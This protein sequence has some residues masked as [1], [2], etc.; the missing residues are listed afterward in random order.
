MTKPDDLAALGA[1]VD[2]LAREN[3]ELRQLLASRIAVPQVNPL[4]GEV[5]PRL[6]L[7]RGEL[8]RRR[9]KGRAIAFVLMGLGIGVGIAAARLV[10]VELF[11]GERAAPPAAAIT[12]ERTDEYPRG[13]TI[14]RRPG[15]FG[16]GRTVDTIF[17]APPPAGVHAPHP[18][19]APAP[20]PAAPGTPVPQPTR[21]PR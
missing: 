13:I 14:I 10:S 6:E 4:T 11:G 17:G 9:F 16:E 1:R 3:A 2:E 18:V 7:S 19:P 5:D 20:V 15:G 21:A 8:R 12:F